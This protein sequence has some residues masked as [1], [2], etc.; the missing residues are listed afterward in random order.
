MRIRNLEPEDYSPLIAVI[1]QWWGGRHMTGM[2]PMLFF[3]HFRDTSFA[4]E[5]HGEVIAFLVGFVSQAHPTQAYIHF[6]GVHP[7]HRSRGLGARLYE[8]F[9]EAV[10]ARGC[11]LVR[12]V[13]SPVNSGSLGFHQRMGFAAEKANG[14]Y[15]GVACSLNYDGPDEHRVLLVKNL[16]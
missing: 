15:N 8:R 7:E 1:D 14:D 16:E 2:L 10:R 13:T 4:I 3:T 11:A 6:V 12:C 9:F 5:E